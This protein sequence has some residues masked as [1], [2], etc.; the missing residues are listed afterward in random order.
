LAQ[1]S[2]EQ[3]MNE[4]RVALRAALVQAL[5]GA[6]SIQGLLAAGTRTAESIGKARDI[7]DEIIIDT[8]EVLGYGTDD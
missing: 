1:V 8:S 4:D 6:A 5:D 3:V 7:A 2:N